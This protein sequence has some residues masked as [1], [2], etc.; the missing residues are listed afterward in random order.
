M[1]K[2]GI[3]FLALL[4][5]LEQLNPILEK[6]N[7]ILESREVILEQTDSLLEQLENKFEN[8]NFIR[9]NKKILELL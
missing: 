8:R 6:L 5:L 7:P 1:F 4:F 9:T 2:K 3:F